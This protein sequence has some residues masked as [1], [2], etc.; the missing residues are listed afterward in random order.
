MKIKTR[1]KFTDK[2]HLLVDVPY[3]HGNV[4]WALNFHRDRFDWIL[5]QKPDKYSPDR[6]TA[7][8]KNILNGKKLRSQLISKAAASHQYSVLDKIRATIKGQ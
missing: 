2:G 5:F 3:K 6:V 8:H 1:V 7:V 4:T